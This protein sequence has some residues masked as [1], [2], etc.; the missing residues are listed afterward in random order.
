MFIL[1]RKVRLKSKTFSIKK[2]SFKKI[3]IVKKYLIFFS[4]IN[5]SWLN[6]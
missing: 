1:K 3:V 6:E 2:Q 5:T 4:W